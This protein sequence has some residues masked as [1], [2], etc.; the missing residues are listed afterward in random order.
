MR[1][2]PANVKLCCCCLLELTGSSRHNVQLRKKL[3]QLPGYSLD[4]TTHAHQCKVTPI[5]YVAKAPVDVPLYIRQ[6]K[7]IYYM[8]PRLTNTMGRI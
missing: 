6:Y 5:L 4:K 1:Y 8:F 2:V 3:T 7:S